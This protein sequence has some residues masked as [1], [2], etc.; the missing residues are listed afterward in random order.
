MKDSLL[1]RKPYLSGLGLL[2]IGILAFFIMLGN[3]L[4]DFQLLTQGVTVQGIATDVN[5]FEDREDNGNVSRYFFI[6]YE[7]TTA[8]DETIS[9]VV[10]VPGNSGDKG[11]RTGQGLY[12][13]YLPG[14]PHTNRLTALS[15][16]TLTGWIL[17]HVLFGLLAI[18][19]GCYLLYRTWRAERKGKR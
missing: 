2:G 18:G 14:D 12:I 15:S 9:G 16:T 11:Y 10:E 5:D 19:P 7:F 17:K 13:Q 6:R 1:V 3:P 8:A 4:T